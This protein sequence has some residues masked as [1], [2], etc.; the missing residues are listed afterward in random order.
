MRGDFA[1][2]TAMKADTTQFLD[3]YFFNFCCNIGA[4]KGHLLAKNISKCLIGSISRLVTTPM[5]DLGDLI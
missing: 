3:C 4:A 1:N 5:F 2:H